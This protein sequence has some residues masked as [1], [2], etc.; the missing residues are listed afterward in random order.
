MEFKSIG[1]YKTHQFAL[2]NQQNIQVAMITS[3]LFVLTKFD[4]MSVWR[5]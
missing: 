1:T 5:K 2:S 3:S 4:S